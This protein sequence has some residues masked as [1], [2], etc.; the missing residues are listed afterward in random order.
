[1]SPRRPNLGERIAAVEHVRA[2]RATVEETAAHFGIEVREVERWVVAHADERTLLLGEIRGEI[3]GEPGRL[4]QQAQ[5]LR[6]LI[7]RADRTLRF[8]HAE[9]LSRKL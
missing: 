8:L 5:R 3:A 7:A 1:M 4:A 6:R 9:L 2:G